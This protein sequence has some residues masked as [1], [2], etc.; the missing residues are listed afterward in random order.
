MFLYNKK[1]EIYKTEFKQG[2][3]NKIQWEKFQYWYYCYS[4]FQTSELLQNVPVF[5]LF[6]AK[7]GLKMCGGCGCLETVY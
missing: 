5:K 2:K 6:D 3:N 4:Q 7:S 1:V